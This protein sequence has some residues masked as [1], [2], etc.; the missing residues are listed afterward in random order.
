MTVWTVHM[1]DKSTHMKAPCVLGSHLGEFLMGRR[2]RWQHIHWKIYLVRT[3]QHCTGM[4]VAWLVPW[5]VAWF[6]S[7]ILCTGVILPLRI[8][9]SNI[10]SNSIAIA[11]Y[12]L[13]SMITC[14]SV[15][16]VPPRLLQFAFIINQLVGKNLVKGSRHG[17]T[18]ASP[19]TRTPW[20]SPVPCCRRLRPGSR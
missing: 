13:E 11:C 2:K 19:A 17:Q 5:L 20:V 3:R 9:S 15:I 16:G 8:G 10:I 4:L 18:Q 6:V 1:Y 14:G 7:L 12:S